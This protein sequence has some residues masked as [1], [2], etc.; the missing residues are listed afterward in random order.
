MIVLA[1]AVAVVL[2]GSD[3]F[4]NEAAI[5]GLIL[6]SL[7]PAAQSSLSLTRPVEGL[8]GGVVALGVGALVFPPDPRVLVRRPRPASSATCG[9][10]SAR[11]PPRWRRAT[12]TT[13]AGRCAPPGARRR[14]RRAGRG[15]RHAQETVALPPPRRGA[16]HAVARHVRT[17]EHLDFAVRNTRIL[18]RHALRL[19]PQRPQR[20][21]RHHGVRPR[22]RPRRRGPRLRARRPGPRRGRTQPRAAPRRASRATASSAS[23]IS[24]SPRSSPRCGRPRSTSSARPSCWARIPSAPSTCRPRSCSPSRRRVPVMITG[25]MREELL[26]RALELRPLLLEQQAATEERTFFAPETHELFREAGLLQAAR[27]AQVR[28]PGGRPPDLLRGD[29]LHRAR[30]PRRRAGSCACRPATRCSSRATS[31]RARRTRSSAPSAASS[32]RR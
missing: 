21:G 19:H 24:S 9:S 30:L 28:R 8:I 16:R 1:M 10:R 29:D 27:P 13:P 12:P 3:L 32:S 23:P 26:S 15:V 5:S 17:G 31:R 7:V 2:R 18:A 11:S 14:R 20:A 6:V 22:A 4:V 25:P